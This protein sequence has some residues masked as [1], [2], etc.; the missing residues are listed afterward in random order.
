[1]FLHATL[2]YFSLFL[3]LAD[4]RA[5]AAKREQLTVAIAETPI[6]ALER[7]VQQVCVVCFFG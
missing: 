7:R 3:A 6:V 4:L 1:M 5:R 2:A